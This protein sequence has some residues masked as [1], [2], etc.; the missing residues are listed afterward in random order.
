MIHQNF[1][2][3]FWMA[4][5]ISEEKNSVVTN[6]V[7]KKTTDKSFPNWN[8]VAFQNE[9]VL[10]HKLWGLSLLR[11]P[12]GMPYWFPSKIPLSDIN[13]ILLIKAKI[14]YYNANI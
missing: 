14:I 12:S 4:D 6:L 3:S 7:L 10:C 8:I 2:V 11:Y 1:V 9:A 13:R 5:S